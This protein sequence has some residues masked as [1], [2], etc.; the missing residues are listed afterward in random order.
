MHLA[1]A[2][3]KRS[4]IL[5]RCLKQEQKTLTS[6]PPDDWSNTKMP[7]GNQ[8]FRVLIIYHAQRRGSIPKCT[9]FFKLTLSWDFRRCVLACCR[10]ETKLMSLWSC[11]HSPQTPGA[12]LTYQV[13]PLPPLHRAVRDGAK[14]HVISSLALC[15]C[16]FVCK[17]YTKYYMLC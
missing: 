9:Y 11:G 8:K 1:F 3:M 14:K 4:T 2:I 6:H 5:T 16:V 15:V 7:P 13:P 17:Y 12:W 10:P